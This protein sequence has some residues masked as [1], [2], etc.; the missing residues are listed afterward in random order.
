MIQSVQAVVRSSVTFLGAALLACT[1]QA[2]PPFHAHPVH[3]NPADL[4]L[5]RLIVTLRPAAG[6]SAAA[7]PASQTVAP[8]LE[9]FNRRQPVQ[10][11]LL[12]RLATGAHLVQLDQPQTTTD[13]DVLIRQWQQDPAV[14]RVEVDWRVLPA[15]EPTDP[16]YPQ[17][18][19]LA[20]SA[21]GIR[22]PLAWDQ[23]RGEGVVVAV[24][25]TGVVA[26]ADL[27]ANLLP[28]YDFV[29]ST[30][31]AND[32]NGRDSDP[33][34]PGDGVSAGACGGGFP[35]QDQA[36][37]W[38]G[39]HVAGIVAAT[40]DN[41][42]GVTGVAPGAQ[43]LPVRVL[44]RCGGYTS[45]VVDALYWAAGLAVGSLPANPHP[46]R[47]INLSLSNAQPA[48]CTA[49]FAEA[50]AAVRGAGA[51]VVVAAG[52]EGG[53]AD[54]Y[55]PGNCEG[56]FSVAA[57]GPAGE[58]AGYSNYGASVDMAAPGGDMST[59][60]D[61]AG[62]LSTGNS[63]AQA[64]E[65]DNYLLMQGT[66]MATPHVTGAA[67]LLY[68]VAADPTPQA[69]ENALR[70]TARTLPS[71]CTGCGAGLLD[72]A[73]ALQQMTGTSSLLPAADLALALKGSTGKFVK[74][75]ANPGQ[76]TIR[77]RA[78]ISNQGPD[79]ADTLILT[80]LFPATVTFESAAP[81]QGQ[82]N[83]DGTRCDLG[84]LASGAVASVTLQV[85]TTE[86]GTLPF[87]A[88]VSSAASDPVTDNNY[89]QKKFG[90]ALGLPVLVWLLWRRR[91]ISR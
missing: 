64:P 26:H 77:Y 24:L 76:G 22:A 32:G 80:N 62:I 58:R 43:W 53:D 71:A 4:P 51:L 12:R 41:G 86:T 2:A 72:A 67:A 81:S 57:T 66:S 85:R 5:D 1:A 44:G 13:M 10:G 19:S 54:Q 8:A 23:T 47:V 63:G 78:D 89:V 40:A 52:N 88:Q 36:S 29:S 11:R 59:A 84:L 16:L 68:A 31:M 17:Q 37:S 39:T 90:G 55:P 28:G 14:A 61:P 42:L 87:Q 65:T 15:A 34:D 83:S 21:G 35:A 69:V 3:P 38:H 56:A 6:V 75:P 79:S 18:W 7:T 25:D 50:I 27:L 74:D 73:A 45:D 9:R 20:D 70:Q 33:A 82:C 60:T 91:P 48:A 46:A 30:F 49:T